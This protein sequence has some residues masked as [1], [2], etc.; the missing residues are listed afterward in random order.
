MKDVLHALAMLLLLAF[1]G[2]STLVSPTPIIERSLPSGWTSQ[3][4]Y[5]D[6]TNGV[7]ALSGASYANS[8]GMS[9]ESCIAFCAQS[10]YNYAGVEYAQEC[11]KYSFCHHLHDILTILRLRVCFAVRSKPGSF[12]RL[13]YGLFWIKCRDLR[14]WQQTQRV[15]EWQEHNV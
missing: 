3:G 10:G 5:I 14:R 11:C 13:Q 12:V 7:R 2:I 9:Q 15:L 4:C 8:T 1:L 6:N